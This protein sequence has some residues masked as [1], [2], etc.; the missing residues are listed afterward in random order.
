M[1]GAVK[2]VKLREN[3]LIEFDLDGRVATDMVVM[4]E[5]DTV[6]MR[7]RLEKILNV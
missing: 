1:S 5:D 7:Y 2:R 6:V 4:L 3:S